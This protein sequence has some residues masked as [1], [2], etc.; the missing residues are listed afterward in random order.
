LE[1]K[2]RREDAARREKERL[3]RELEEQEMQ[4]A[5]QLLEQARKKGKGGAVVRDTD[6][7]SRCLLTRSQH[8]DS[9]GL[10]QCGYNC[11]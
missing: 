11:G 2:R 9:A 8:C 6:S 1:E 4:E 7:R 10:P 3:E 5:R